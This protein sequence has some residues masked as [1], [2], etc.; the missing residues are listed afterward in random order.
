ME[1]ENWKGRGGQGV[2]HLFRQDKLHMFLQ[3]KMIKKIQMIKLSGTDAYV[4]G[5]VCTTISVIIVVVTF[6]YSAEIIYGHLEKVR[7]N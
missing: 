7:K 2:E 6:V 5:A 1:M 3:Q 4:L